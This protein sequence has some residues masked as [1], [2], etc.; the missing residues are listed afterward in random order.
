MPP[1]F[2]P[3]MLNFQQRFMLF[4]WSFTGDFLKY[5]IWI[6]FIFLKMFF[7]FTGKLTFVSMGLPSCTHL[8][9][10]RA[11]FLSFSFFFLSPSNSFYSAI[12]QVSCI[13]FPDVF[14]NLQHIVSLETCVNRVALVLFGANSF[15]SI[16]NKFVITLVCWNGVCV[17]SLCIMQ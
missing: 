6:W 17:C 2:W 1:Y 13:S 10:D 3:G 9:R 4:F 11:A 15:N 8:K 12:L 16:C 7:L 14:Q 5:I